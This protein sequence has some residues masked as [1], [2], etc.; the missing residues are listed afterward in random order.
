VLE[1][2]REAYWDFESNRAE[3]QIAFEYRQLEFPKV[4]SLT[5]IINTI[6]IMFMKTRA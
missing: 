5:I 6:I 2:E 4:L 1:A 3:G